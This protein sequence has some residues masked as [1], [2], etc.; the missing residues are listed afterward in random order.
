MVQ[1]KADSPTLSPPCIV[2][3]LPDGSARLY[4]DARLT[5]ATVLADFPRHLLLSTLS[6]ATPRTPLSPA[7]PLKPGRTYFLLAETRRPRNAAGAAVEVSVSALDGQFPVVSA[8]HPDGEFPDEESPPTFR[9]SRTLPSKRGSARPDAPNAP[10]RDWGFGHDL[11]SELYSANVVPAGP[12]GNYY[13][14]RRSSESYGPLS[15]L[16]ALS[17]YSPPLSDGGIVTPTPGGYRDARLPTWRE[18]EPASATGSI[19]T[20][21]TN[22]TCELD[23]RRKS[24]ASDARRAANPILQEIDALEDMT[25]DAASWSPHGH[26]H[27]NYQDPHN[28]SL[29]QSHGEPITAD[30][31]ASSKPSLMDRLPQLK[32]FS[33]RNRGSTNRK[34]SKGST[35][36]CS[37]QNIHIGIPSS[38]DIFGEAWNNLDDK[39]V[40]Y[41]DSRI[42]ARR[43]KLHDYPI[44]IQS[45]PR[46][47]ACSED[48]TAPGVEVFPRHLSSQAAEPYVFAYERHHHSQVFY[49]KSDREAM[50]AGR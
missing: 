1:A 34:I 20:M 30:R 41:T 39:S 46:V 31:R 27:H 19:A 7:T 28:A 13:D 50:F 44:S 40:M 25:Y 49:S 6:S 24:M 23:G 36:S 35:G 18:A 33:F 2:V 3:L 45:D 29:R 16:S 22:C 17:P 32:V 11:S 14:G 48:V 21:R 5:A 8:F 9:K 12:A 43:N 37:Q 47:H 38:G 15:P 10:Q 42:L 26:S 4:D